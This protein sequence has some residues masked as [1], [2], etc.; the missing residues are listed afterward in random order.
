MI[1]VKRK[2]AIAPADKIGA[3]LPK[4]EDKKS[5]SA[6]QLML[7]SKIGGLRREEGR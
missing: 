5:I 3:K 6:F 2:E 7:D 4:K 1:E